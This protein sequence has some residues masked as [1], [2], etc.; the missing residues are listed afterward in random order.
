MK[1]IMLVVLI[2]LLLCTCMGWRGYVMK[3]KRIRKLLVGSILVF[4]LAMNQISGSV[5]ADVW[6]YSLSLSRYEQEYTC[7]CWAA[8]AKMV[9]FYYGYTSIS[10]TGIAIAVHGH[11]GNI[12]ATDSET[13]TAINFA[14]S[15]SKTV[16][17][18]NG[19]KNLS[20]IKTNISN[21]NPFVL[22]MHW[23]SGGN[24]V[25]VCKGYN[26]S[27]LVIVDP[28]IGCSSI[29]AYPYSDLISGTT[30]LSGTGTYTNTFWIT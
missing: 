17:N 27:S 7:W 3:R 5:L 6:A 12:G 2:M 28:G 29:V 10:Q 9:G 25:V 1:K 8:C 20:Q 16:T 13:R 19:T 11:A 15:G 23:D 26:G 14:I 21:G 30:I 24:H 4:S 22:K 18:V